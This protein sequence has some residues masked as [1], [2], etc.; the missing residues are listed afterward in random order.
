V[1]SLRQDAKRYTRVVGLFA[2]LA[3]ATGLLYTVMQVAM[4][5]RVEDPFFTGLLSANCLIIWQI[6]AYFGVRITKRVDPITAKAGPEVAT[7][8]HDRA[9]AMTH[10]QPGLLTGIVFGGAYLVAPWIDPQVWGNEPQM[11]WLLGLF[12]A[13]SNIVTGMALYSLGRFMQLSVYLGGH[14]DVHL[15]EATCPINGFVMDNARRIALATAV[16]SLFA[17]S[18]LMLSQFTLGSAHSIGF[19][20][21]SLFISVSAYT[22]PLVPITM[23]LGELKANEQ[24][25]LSH[26]LQYQFDEAVGRLERLEVMAEDDMAPYTA[27][28]DLLERVRSVRV[29]PPMGAR[30]I[31]TAAWVSLLT[32]TPS[33]VGWVTDLVL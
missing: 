20:V 10:L 11:R 19:A 13:V 14:A 2:L 32:F 12:L 25:R 27:A 3:I 4:H 24:A 1:T 21:W 26:L 31:E 18:S 5:G 16:V 33:I 29:F 22:V 8:A 15:F 7:G 9:I 17:V 30:P 6:V 23:R 28:A